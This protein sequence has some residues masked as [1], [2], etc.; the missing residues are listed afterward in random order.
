MGAFDLDSGSL[1][2]YRVDPWF[3]YGSDNDYIM[4]GDNWRSNLFF[5]D[6]ETF[7]FNSIY[8][9]DDGEYELRSWVQTR[10]NF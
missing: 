8:D 3:E 9:N 6:N 7:V 4:W 2:Y 10:Y 1:W 5:M